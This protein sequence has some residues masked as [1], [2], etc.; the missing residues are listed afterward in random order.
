[1]QI[2]PGEKWIGGRSGDG[3]AH[4]IGRKLDSGRHRHV[5]VAGSQ[6]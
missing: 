5:T 3:Q 1:M 4:L 6:Q 2:M